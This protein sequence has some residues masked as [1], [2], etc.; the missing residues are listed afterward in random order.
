MPGVVDPVPAA[1][2]TDEDVPDWL[3]AVL[4]ISF[5]SRRSEAA[6][7]AAFPI[8]PSISATASRPVLATVPLKLPLELSERAEIRS[9]ELPILAGTGRLDQLVDQLDH[10]LERI[11][12]LAA[13]RAE[14]LL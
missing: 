12:G 8:M 6:S 3:G 9:P 10:P 5:A 7:F 2:D 14:H 11:L 4:A 1:R 13:G